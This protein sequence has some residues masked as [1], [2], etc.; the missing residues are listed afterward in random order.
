MNLLSWLT[1]IEANTGKVD[2]NKC[3]K[4]CE[5]VKRKQEKNKKKKEHN[6]KMKHKKKLQKMQQKKKICDYMNLNEEY[7]KELESKISIAENGEYY[8]DL[9]T[10]KLN[11]SVRVWFTNPC[12]IGVNPNKIK[13]HSCFYFL[14][15]KSKCDIYGL[16]ETNVNWHLLKGSASF[17]SRVKHFWRRFKTVTSHNIH[18]NYGV[19]QRGGTCSAAVGQLAHRVSKT[20]KDES[21]LGRWVWIEFA[22][23]EEYATR[24]YTAYR[25]GSKPPKTSKMTTVYNQQEQYFRNNNIGKDPRDM[26]DEDLEKE[27]KVHICRAN[28]IVMLDINQCAKNG[29]FTLRM[30]KIGLRNAY[31]TRSHG[32]LP[33]THHRGSRPISAIYHSRNLQVMRTGILPIGVG[34]GGDH[35]NMFVDFTTS[36]FLG[37]EMYMVADQTMKTLNL[38][39]SRIYKKF[40]QIL[41]NHLKEHNLLIRSQLLFSKAKYPATPEM[42]NEMEEIDAQLG[43]GITNAL[44]NCRKVR[45]GKIPF[46]ATFRTIQT[47]RRLWAL[48][49]KRKI[50]QR[51]SSSLLKRLCTATGYKNPLSYTMEEVKYKKD[52]CERQYETLLPHAAGERRRFMEELAAANAA[53]LNMPRSKMIKRIMRA[54]QIREQNNIIRSHFPKSKGPTKKVDKVEVRQGEEWIEVNKPK[55]L[56]KALQDENM[57]K[58]HCTNTT[59][60][61]QPNIHENFGN[62]GETSYAEE[63]QRGMRTIPSTLPAMTQAMLRKTAFNSCIP[64]IPITISEEEVKNT[65]KITKEK[66][67]S[68]PSGRYNAV[69]KSMI[70]DP[71]LLKFLTISMNLPFLMGAPYDRWSIFLDIMAFKKPG[72]IKVDTLRSIIISEADWNAAGRIFVTKKMM[73]Q[74]EKYRLLPEEHLGGRK[75]RKSIDGA[76]TKQIYIDNVSAL[77]IPT[78]ILS[79]DASNCYDRMVHKYIS[80][81]CAK[82]GL[83][84]QVMKTLLQPLQ[85]AKHY[86]RTAYGDS[87][88]CFEG[89][90]FQGAGQG[91]TGAAPYWTCISTSMIELMKEAGYTSKL[92][93]PLSGTQI[94]L[95]L[96]A[97][98]DDTEIF[99]TIDTNNIEELIVKTQ[100]ALERWKNVLSA[101][102]GAMRSKKCAW[103]LLDFVINSCHR[104]FKTAQAHE[105]KN[106]EIKDDDGVIRKIHR[107]QPDDPREYLGVVQTADSSDDHQLKTIYDNIRKWND[108][109][110]KSKLPNALNLQALMNRIHKKILY[111]LPATNL[112]QIQLQK[113]S[114]TL[115]TTSLPK[116]GI[117]RTFPLR[118]RTIPSYFFGLGL[119][120]LYIELQIGKIREFLTHG[121]DSTVLGNQLQCGLET[122]QIQAGV[123]HLILNQSYKRYGDLVDKG[124]IT[125]M[126]QFTSNMDYKFK[127]WNNDLD[128]QREGDEFLMEAFIQYG[129]PK[130]DLRILNQCRCF[131]QVMTIA[132]L[133]NGAGNAIATNFLQGRLDMSRR[134]T[135]IWPPVKRPSFNAWHLWA[136]TL[137][138]V[139]C[140]NDRGNTL[141]CPLGQW[142]HTKYC[143]WDWYFDAER[144][145]LYHIQKRHIIEYTAT[146]ERAMKT[147]ADKKWYKARNILKD[148]MNKERLMRASVEKQSKG[149]RLVTYQGAASVKSVTQPKCPQMISTLKQIVAS[150]KIN[151]PPLHMDNFSSVTIDDVKLIMHQSIRIVSDGSY[152]TQQSA[153]STIIECEDK[154]VQIV[155]TG[156]GVENHPSDDGKNTDP[157]RSEMMGLYAG[158]VVMSILE[159][160]LKSGFR[161]TLT[162]DNDSALDMVGTYTW[163]QATQPHYDI[164]SAAIALRKNM[165]SD[166]K[167]E[168]VLGHA[169]QKEKG[170]KSTRTELL[171]QSCDILAKQTREN[172][173]PIGPNHL[174]HERLSLWEGN[175]KV[176]NDL[177]QTIKWKYYARKAMPVL[178]KKYEWEQTIFR[179]IDWK[180]LQKAMQLLTTYSTIWISK[181][182]TGFLPLGIYL[183]R[184]KEWMFDYCPRCK[185]CTETRS[186]L[187]RC[188]E[189]TSA[190]IFRESLEVM[191]EWLDKMQ[192]P[193]DIKIHILTRITSWRMDQPWNVLSGIDCPSPLRAQDMIGPW[194]HFMEGRLHCEWKLHMQSHYE[195]IK[196]KRTGSQWVSQIIQRMWKL[197]F[198]SQWHHRNKFVHNNIDK[199]SSI[200]RQREE[201]QQKVE[202][203]YKST[204][205]YNLLVK[206]QH[207]YDESLTNIQKLEDDAM[208]AWLNEHK[209]AVRDRDETFQAEIHDSNLNLRKWMIPKRT[210]IHMNRDHRQ[211][212]QRLKSY[213]GE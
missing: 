107:Y 102:G 79:T 68:S 23:R 127:G 92:T 174:Y 70:M 35:R 164:V 58:Y 8:G 199:T 116:C 140:N 204:T 43:R 187:V 97:F 208:K 121:L 155:L 175:K 105:C 136:T 75:G 150:S 19:N 40:I 133:A 128:I 160:Y 113:V 205:K 138:S 166:I 201:L 154:K 3:D 168:R 162:S 126:W 134:S 74:A 200:T 193:T 80:M 18:A 42:K 188:P 184:R 88:T 34:V 143:D 144:K 135:F 10:K 2:T 57:K 49:H 94:L 192:T 28:I 170:R 159:E 12:G 47:Q 110:T 30:E 4:T 20:G 60:L 15:Y 45:M 32:D 21:G 9:H 129:V 5:S 67:T 14:R 63:I 76:I 153:Y 130:N 101:T 120:D 66:K 149:V 207:L 196:S 132:D 211:K 139:L 13:N 212:R 24:V 17:Y 61:M 96:I 183:Q 1:V 190:K 55:E 178:C 173:Q 156:A 122:L 179:M 100:K 167:T 37:Q 73:H 38:N 84:K 54:E 186:H 11:E 198:I 77:R 103:V 106:L 33:A 182:V 197:F 85:E 209:L 124:W 151:L 213:D 157:Y 93:T 56:I 48:V 22:G 161:I 117:I 185:E 36:S 39:D 26:F 87:T 189:K 90:D 112:S 206:D 147:R 50:G 115:Y 64:R 142:L 16:A 7:K 169:D 72:D 172:A 52:E 71:Y 114:N 99:L 141:K 131:L 81:M 176:Y 98:V 194:N 145:V 109:I 6:N 95:S 165:K 104:E 53:E 69:Y 180:S 62:F 82:W 27:I 29:S 191:E 137:R 158:L 195:N 202:L 86:T 177:A 181:F 148:H 41:K 59:P 119:P 125:H 108:K 203:A 51:V 44:R 78:V 123:Q 210:R 146:H 46:S 31:K 91:N 89:K 25:P 65:W 111:P 152:K 171:N 83:E 163:A 118:Y